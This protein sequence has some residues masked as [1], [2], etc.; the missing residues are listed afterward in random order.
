MSTAPMNDLLGVSVDE[1]VTLLKRRG[2]RLPF[3][4]GAFVALEACERLLEGPAVIGGADVRI[5]DDGTVSVFAPP[6]SASGEQSARAL[7]TLLAHLLVAAGPDVPA[8][9]LSLVERGPSDGRWELRRLRDDLEASLVPLN[10]AAARRVLS[11]FLR[12][13][14][15][16]TASVPP[17]GP[18]GAGGGGDV[19]ADLDALIGNPAR[20][21]PPPGSAPAVARARVPSTAPGGAKSP[22]AQTADLDALLAGVGSAPAPRIGYA[23]PTSDETTI[24][25]IDQPKI[26]VPLGGLASRPLIDDSASLDAP[27]IAR[28]RAVARGEGAPIVEAPPKRSSR[29]AS[30]LPESPPAA[31][32]PRP[33]PR[34][35]PTPSEPVP[36][37]KKKKKRDPSSAAQRDADATPLIPPELA[38]PSLLDEPKKSRGAVVWVFL[39]V[40]V[41]GGFA[42]GLY[43]LRPDLFGAAP[44]TPERDLDAERAERDRRQQQLNEEHAGRFGTLVVEVAPERSQVLLFIGRGPARA[45]NLP[46]GLAHEFVAIA[47]GRAPTRAIVPADAEWEQ[48]ADGA[49]YELA[50]QTPNQEVALEDLDLGRTLLPQDVG[51]PGT[52]LGTV[53]VVTTPRGA[54]VYQL[55]GFAPQVTIENVRTDEAIELLA[56]AEGHRLERIVVGP[57]DWR[58]EAEGKVA[59]VN[60]TLTERRR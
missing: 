26:E 10:R 42:G 47:D 21:T 58:T 52:T 31:P 5:A 36:T 38:D 53:R 16:A 4:I 2:A 24:P 23:D 13:T 57:S 6:N 8:P 11:R 40:L 56:F 18:G 37:K 9:L 55:A 3:E 46:L 17:P 1:L 7:V 32:P 48:T 45:T 35:E 44:P 50:M 29:G 33:A 27:T 54:K 59:E 25:G 15:R 28:E 41:V 51:T 49:Q 34:K 43:Y 60:V 12:E 20:P 19:D 14:R 39:F 22:E 30:P